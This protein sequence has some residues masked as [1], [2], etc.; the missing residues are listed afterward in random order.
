MKDN[1]TTKDHLIKYAQEV[2]DLLEDDL[3]NK[4]ARRIQ[5]RI[6]VV[7]AAKG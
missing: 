6:D 7:K 1:D 3:L 2:W 4:L 5:K